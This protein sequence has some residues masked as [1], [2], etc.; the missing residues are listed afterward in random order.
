MTADDARD[1]ARKQVDFG[2]DVARHGL[3]NEAA[4]RFE[5]ALDLDVPMCAAAYN[6]LAIAYERFGRLDEARRMYERPATLDE[7]NV[8]IRHNR[9][10]FAEIDDR[11]VRPLESDPAPRL[12]GT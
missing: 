7:G 1:A 2:I 5:R 9:E 8:H 3:W 12:G 6:N 11:R 4:Y 10:L